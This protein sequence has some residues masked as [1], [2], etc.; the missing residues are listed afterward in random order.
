[1]GQPGVAVHEF[2]AKLNGSHEHKEFWRSFYR[3]MF[4]EMVGC[5]FNDGDNAS[6]RMGVDAVL[7]MANGQSIKIDEKGRD[8]DYNDIALEYVSNDRTNAPGWMEKDLSIDYL[9]YA[10]YPAGRAH[11]FPWQMLR[12]AWKRKRD[13]WI[14]AFP[15]IVSRNPGYNTISVGVPVREIWA[16][17]YRCS[18][19]KSDY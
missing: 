10:I 13:E 3:Q 18:T 5:V 17:I 9:A 1:V 14:Q 2:S 11:L 15:P 12:L 16:E 8:K 6:Q 19:V 7:V 4:P